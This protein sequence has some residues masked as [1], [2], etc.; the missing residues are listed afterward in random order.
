MALSR[1][2]RPRREGHRRENGERKLPASTIYVSYILGLTD[3]DRMDI[4]MFG[5]LAAT[6]ALVPYAPAS[7]TC[8]SQRGKPRAV[9]HD[10]SDGSFAQ[11]PRRLHQHL[12]WYGRTKQILRS[13]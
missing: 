7:L 2:D 12:V 3:N 1:I 9:P 6:S 5:G 11:G 13:S 8:L 10:E 4:R